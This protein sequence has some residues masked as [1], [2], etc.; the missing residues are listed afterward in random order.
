MLTPGW[1]RC[2]PDIPL[3]MVTKAQ[4]QRGHIGGS[5]M[6]A[7]SADFAVRRD[8]ARLLKGPEPETHDFPRLGI[9][10][11]GHHNTQWDHVELMLQVRGLVAHASDPQADIT[12]CRL[13][14]VRW[15][16]GPMRIKKPISQSKVGSSFLQNMSVLQS[17]GLRS[18]TCVILESVALPT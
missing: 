1:W 14:R 3:S 17:K 2:P 15:E 7:R 18:V 11:K 4:G 12:S 6:V 9:T 8:R 5:P 13:G 16:M 10:I